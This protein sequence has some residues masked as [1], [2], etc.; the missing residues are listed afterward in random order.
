M[1]LRLFLFPKALTGKP[2]FSKAADVKSPGSDGALSA[3][4]RLGAA[5]LAEVPPGDRMVLALCLALAAASGGFAISMSLK[6]PD[7]G[8]KISS[9]VTRP[10]GGLYWKQPVNVK[11]PEQGEMIGALLTRSVVIDYTPTGS[12][13]TPNQAQGERGKDATIAPEPRNSDGSLASYSI[14]TAANGIAVLE[15]RRGFL[16]VHVGSHLTSDNEILAIEQRNGKWV[17][18]T[19]KGLITQETH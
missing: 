19:A 5:S 13:A 10:Y 18:V 7:G 1:K 6:S 14:V 8:T 16:D 17:V 11:E 15:G 12:L 9:G 4:W 2:N 3:V